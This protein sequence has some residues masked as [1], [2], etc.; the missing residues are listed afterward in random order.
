MYAQRLMTLEL[1]IIRPE[2]SVGKVLRL[3]DEYKVCHL[4]LVNGEEFSGLVY[5]NDLVESDEE[6][7]M[8]ALE[9]RPVSVGPQVH[10]Y[11][12]VSQLVQAEVDALP[13]VH[14]GKF[15]G[16]IDAKTVL[17]FLAKHTHWAGSGAVV[18]LEVPE[19]DLS[20]AEIARLV[21][22]ADSKVLACMTSHDEASSNVVVTL[23][24]QEQD[25]ESVIATFQRYGY[26]I[27]TFYHAPGMEEE[28]RERYEAFMRYL[29][30]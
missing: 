4:P 23:K 25:V 16:C 28:M 19:M 8:A 29:D 24:L 13:V 6:T 22:A 1:P 2:D 5:E 18:V 30:N 10:L 11:D 21:E 20:I 7:P 17:R 15:L 12:V 3:M 14:E 26:T 27:Q 9:A